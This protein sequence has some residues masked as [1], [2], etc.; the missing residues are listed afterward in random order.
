MLGTNQI[1]D[2]NDDRRFQH[3]QPRPPA[4]LAGKHPL[5]AE[6]TCSSFLR[7]RK[8]SV[9]GLDMKRRHNRPRTGVFAGLLFL[10][11]GVVLLLGNMNLFS[12]QPVLSQWWPV[13]LIIVGIKHLVVYRGPSAWVGAL[14]W[15]GTG[16]LF[17]SSTLGYLSAA[18]PTLLWPVLLIWFGVFTVLGCGSRCGG[19]ISDGASRNAAE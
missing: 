2:R 7:V 4:S 19:Q 3:S 13:L 6:K 16:S 1:H 18:I 15:I 14:F 12:V 17:L 10:A 11:L 8:L 9:G 5:F